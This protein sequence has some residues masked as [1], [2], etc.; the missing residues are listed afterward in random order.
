MSWL[1]RKCKKAELKALIIMKEIDFLPEWYK[2]GRRRQLRY[3]TQYI[4]LV[5]MFSVMM[6]WNFVSL[7]SVSKAT[8]KLAKMAAE[9]S[10]VQAASKEFTKI[11]NELAE[12]QIKTRILGEIDSRINVAEVLA[13][14]SFLIDEKVVLSKV[15][16]ISE[17]FSDK[18]QPKKSGSSAIRVVGTEPDKRQNLPLG[19]V[20]FKVLINGIAADAS[21][22]AALVCKLED[23]PYFCR[24]YPSISRNKTIQVSG[25]SGPSAVLGTRINSGAGTRTALTAGSLQVSEFEISCYLANYRVEN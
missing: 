24:V 15:E 10:E 9:Q 21:D 13:E 23:S 16:F 17:R 7:N 12:L 8:A 14:M 4:V 11:K 1:R 20:C 5:C 2:N 25:N 19:N 6:V 22:V 18:Q 3:S